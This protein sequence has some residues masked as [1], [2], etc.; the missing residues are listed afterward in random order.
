M[1]GREVFVAQV[2]RTIADR[3]GSTD[4][5]F[6]FGLS[7]KWGEG[8]TEFLNKL[9]VILKTE[10]FEVLDLNPW[11]YG[12]DKTTLLRVLLVKL[13]E[14]RHWSDKFRVCLMRVREHRFA[15]AFRA[16]RFR[17]NEIARLRRDSSSRRVSILGLVAVFAISLSSY[18]LYLKYVSPLIA[19]DWLKVLLPVLVFLLPFAAA[20][21]DMVTTSQVSSRAVTAADEFDELARL[22]MRMPAEG[23]PTSEARV[24][25]RRVVV[26]VD[27]LDRVTEQVARQVLDNLRTFFDL[28]CISFVVTGDHTVLEQGLGR[29]LK[30]D[31][32]NAQEQQ[33]EG[34]RFLKKI[35]NL[36]W[37]LPVLVKSD[38]AAFVE[39]Q[40]LQRAR[41]LDAILGEADQAVLRDWL[42]RYTDRNL[43]HVIRLLEMFI[44]TM[45][46]VRAQHSAAAETELGPLDDV[47]TS[48][49]LMA[50]VLW[51][52][53]RCAPFFELLLDDPEL[54]ARF[55]KAVED[56]GEDPVRVFVDSVSKPDGESA[57]GVNVLGRE[58]YAF[59]ER[60]AY[61]EPRFWHNPDGQVVSGVAPFVHLAGDASFEDS[62]GPQPD[63]FIRLL[64]TKNREVLVPA[65]GNCSKSVAA[66]VAQ[67]S[68]AALKSVEDVAERFA[69]LTVL[70]DALS[71]VETTRPAIPV[72]ALELIDNADPLLANLPDEHRVSVQASIWSLADRAASA[73]SLP[74][75]LTA[76]RDGNDLRHLPDTAYGPSGSKVV[77]TWLVAYHPI[78]PTDWL[79][80]AERLLPQL[81]AD[82]T[83]D[84]LASLAEP[85][86]REILS[87]PDN[88]AR[89]RRLAL[90]AEHFADGS[91]LVA[92]LVVPNAVSDAALWDWAYQAAETNDKASWAPE[93]LETAL[94]GWVWDAPDAQQLVQR[95]QTASQRLRIASSVEGMWK[96]LLDSRA[97]DL[98][99]SLDQLTL[100]EA[101]AAF[102]P[103]AEVATVLYLSRVAEVKSQGGNEA[104][105]LDMAR[106]LDPGK[107][108][109]AN[110]H[111]K[112][113]RKALQ[114]LAT[115]PKAKLKQ[116]QAL[117]QPWWLTWGQR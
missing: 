101:T 30:P 108:M 53:D 79:T 21:V 80:H 95:I 83:A 50:R 102:A 11:K 31:T 94:V 90:L 82:S 60:F 57:S 14:S 70:L 3:H 36:Y 103:S 100:F 52:Q 78:N 45:E 68:C 89:D 93:D 88:G 46:L 73:S 40:M 67:S 99:V 63:D 84:T 15:A 10:D 9:R 7:G 66:S 91:E 85:L 1:K 62:K 54:L 5:S 87:D 64:A 107:W 69:Q 115:H 71:G 43:R 65:L 44:F 48:P 86:A 114:T 105:A 25:P 28:P 61:E 19:A 29:E 34:R 49:L 116:L 104:T 22:T 56:G 97:L 20:L 33:E 77:A 24:R 41:D 96:A 17:S 16:L 6:V 38:L 13:L 39:A 59:L 2:A 81:E 27:D 76:F 74:S 110:V 72:F 32:T 18:W 23:Q 111:A 75:V 109:W 113:A 8:K 26:F 106:C 92:K 117:L 51:L 4:E 35:F 112:P 55:D 58:Q 42:I 12:T 37:Q 98:G 47:V